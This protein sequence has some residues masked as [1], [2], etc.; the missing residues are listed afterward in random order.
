MYCEDVSKTNQGGLKQRK[1]K[2]VVHHANCENPSRCL[3]SLYK[4]HNSLCPKNRPAHSFYLTPL[5]KLKKDCWYKASPVGHG[6]LAE[7][8]PRLMKSAG[9]EGYFTN[10]SLRVTAATRT[11]DAQ[12]DEATIM[13]KTGHRS[14][15]GV[16]AYKR[17]SEKFRELS[18]AVLN[19][20]K[21]QKLE[22]I[23]ESAD[24][25]SDVAG[26]ENTAPEVSLFAKPLSIPGI[27]FGSATNFTIN[28]PHQTTSLKAGFFTSKT[29]D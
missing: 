12:L 20:Q 11:Y 9:I 7:V 29:P 25:K 10:H 22:P 1:L 3:I 14:V 18:S 8:V 16:R 28:L 21:K 5:A 27:H 17:T 26:S 13:S 2:E 24:K 15:D 4:L 6:K 19:T 23:P